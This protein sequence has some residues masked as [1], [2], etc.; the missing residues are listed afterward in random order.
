MEAV[1]VTVMFAHGFGGE[2]NYEY[3][4]QLTSTLFFE[5]GSHTEPGA[6]SFRWNGGMA[7]HRGF[8]ATTSPVLGMQNKPSHPA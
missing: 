2:K 6:K 4:P 3:I 1:I 8:S 5:R 7:S